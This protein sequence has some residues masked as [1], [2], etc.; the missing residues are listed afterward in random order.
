MEEN[1]LKIK[2]CNFSFKNY[3]DYDSEGYYYD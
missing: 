3:F 2:K 1:I